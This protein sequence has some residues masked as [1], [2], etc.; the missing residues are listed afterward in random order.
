MKPLFSHIR[1]KGKKRYIDKLPIQNA[2]GQDY[3]LPDSYLINETEW[4][5]DF[6]LWPQVTFIDLCTYLT[7]TY[8]TMGE[9]KNY[10]SLSAYE[11]VLSGK[12]LNF[13]ISVL[14]FQNPTL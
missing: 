2:N 14:F 10:R 4:K 1:G 11:Y 3:I 5:G 7:E 13:I 12:L 8:C 9:L 6:Y